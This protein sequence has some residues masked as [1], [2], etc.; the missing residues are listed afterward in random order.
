[1][2][3]TPYPPPYRAFILWMWAEAND[4]AQMSAASSWRFSLESIVAGDEPRPERR[5]FADAEELL[6][7]LQAEMRVH[8]PAG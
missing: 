1:M 8:P 6:A 5:G 4:L 3:L 2:H 7:Y